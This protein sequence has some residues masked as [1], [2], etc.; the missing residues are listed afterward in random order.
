MAHLSTVAVPV[1]GVEL[2]SQRISANLAESSKTI[3]TTV[4]TNGERIYQRAKTLQDSIDREQIEHLRVERRIQQEVYHRLGLDFRDVAQSDDKRSAKIKRDRAFDYTSRFRR[5]NK[6]GKVHE[7]GLQIDLSEESD[8]VNYL[9]HYSKWMSKVRLPVEYEAFV[10]FARKH[11]RYKHR[12][13][14]CTLLAHK[15]SKKALMLN[16]EKLNKLTKKEFISWNRDEAQSFELIA[17]AGVVGMFMFLWYMIYTI[18]QKSDAFMERTIQ[19]FNDSQKVVNDV[20]RDMRK[21]ISDVSINMQVEV[22]NVSDTLD[23]T[24]KSLVKEVEKVSES[25]TTTTE[26]LTTEVKDVSEKAQ[27]MLAKGT[28]L[29]DSGNDL[30]SNIKSMGEKAWEWFSHVYEKIK[31]FFTIDNIFMAKITSIILKVIAIVLAFEFVRTM[32]PTYTKAVIRFIANRAGIKMVSEDRYFVMREEKDAF[33]WYDMYPIGDEA[34]S[35]DGYPGPLGFIMELLRKNVACVKSST[36]YSYC[37]VI[38]KLT[39]TAKSLEWIFEHI[40]DLYE[41]ILEMWTGQPRGRERFERD[42]LSFAAEVD[43][44]AAKVDD[45]S[46]EVQFSSET[47]ALQTSLELEERRLKF[48]TAKRKSPPRPFFG[49]LLAK[50]M[51]ILTRKKEAYKIMTR[52]ARKRATPVWL[53]IHGDQGIGKTEAVEQ[54][55][56]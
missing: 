29:L 37:D 36:F 9:E 49:Q 7:F 28:E 48:E 20:A 54:L 16:R 30:I 22:Q 50:K 24:A 10:D 26:D 55:M 5:F 23:R 6:L 41:W 3:S 44:F 25:I 34:Q 27:T 13:L 4:N 40:H 21:E 53:Y 33:K 19:M 46:V 31:S 45:P 43:K 15:G 11:L 47:K 2:S 17:G 18:G 12:Y 14:A 42:V 39:N 38:P 1:S 35:S 56:T 32:F 51:D 52:S 8:V